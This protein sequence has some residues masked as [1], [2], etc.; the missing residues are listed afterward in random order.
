MKKITYFLY[1]SAICFSLPS[2]GQNF[3]DKYIS[4]PLIYTPIATSTN[5]LNQP[6]DLD[7]KP[8]TNELWVVNYGT[9]TGG[10]SVILYNAGQATQTFEYR[11]DSHTSHFMRFPPA[12]AFSD[13]GE[14][15]CVSEIQ[16]TAGGTSTFMGPGLWTADTNIY[17]RTGQNG[18][19]LGYPLG[20]HL[21]MLHQSPNAMGIAH[22]SAKIYWVFDGW[23]G[24]ICK[25]DFVSDHSPG[26][27]NHS[28]GKI[29]RYTGVNVL[30][31]P[32]IP[33][34]MVMDKVSKWLYIVDGGN[35]RVIRIASKTGAVTATLSVPGTASE[36]LAG[37][38]GVTGVT[39]Q[40][41][42]T[43]TSQPCGI[44]YS[45]NRLIVSDYTTGAIRIYDT[46]IPTPTLMG[47]IA[48]GSTGIMGVKIGTDGKIWFVNNLQNKVYRIDPLPATVDASILEIT[49]P[50]IENSEPKFYSPKFNQCVGSVSPIVSLQN[51]GSVLLTSVDI[52]YTIDGGPVTT[53]AWTGSLATGV[54]ISVS[55][56]NSVV[57]NGTH[58]IIAYT[59]N[60]NGTTDLNL[61]N[62][63]KEGSFRSINPIMPY[64][65]TENF[66]AAVFP[67]AGWSY[68]GYNKYCFMS[69]IASV[70]GFGAGLGCFKMDNFSGTMNI[71]GQ[72]D[73]LIT[74]RI[75]F[76]SATGASSLKFDVAYAMYDPTTSDGLEVRVSTN[77]GATWTSIYN[78]AGT[79][80]ATAP[81]IT[82]AF[83]PTAAQWKTETTS[84]SAYAGMPDVM[85]M[86]VTTSNWGNHIYMD[87]INLSNPLGIKEIENIINI[88]V[89]PN[90]SDGEVLVNANSGGG[91]KEI[92]VSN[93][94]GQ[95][96]MNVDF[97]N[98][99]ETNW[100]LNFSSCVNGTYIIKVRTESGVITKKIIIQK[101]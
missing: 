21:D 17:A 12:I 40:T 63:K 44:D 19:A 50:A 1:S 20:S 56:P 71:T 98:S 58:K 72:K 84:M 2:I 11:K 31:T 79:F 59:A 38:F 13:I 3:I 54:I 33:S 43:Y 8:N 90:P 27:D 47:T 42:D 57:T 55:L 36:P 88:E 49:S 93:I 26:Y 85:L 52:K 53:F 39:Q 66:T 22:D 77:C 80:L 4:D 67:P 61:L 78:K 34:H 94:I 89:Y 73:Y 68:V 95:Q 48:T 74:P 51:K 99:T 81:D 5:S 101:D 35:K 30:R 62:D 16:S 100:K 10:T 23:N 28:A 60:P 7:F 86:F 15:A 92:L 76:S 96:I 6:K 41:I 9:T 45:N 46:S 64:P 69:R 65:F 37:Y 83:V 82:T 18:W 91:I 87:N 14:W 32:G 75:N 25:Y 24:N 70:G 97:K 29:W